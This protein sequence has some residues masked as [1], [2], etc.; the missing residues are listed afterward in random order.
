MSGEFFTEVSDASGTSLLDVAKRQWS[1]EML[2]G[3]EIPRAWMPEVTESPW[4]RP[5]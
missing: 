1:D 5:G 4:P 2:G 3:C